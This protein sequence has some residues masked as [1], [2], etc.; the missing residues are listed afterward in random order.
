VEFY[1]NQFTQERDA[2]SFSLLRHIPEL[3]TYEEN[4]D[5]CKL[6]ELDEVRKAIFNLNRDRASGPDGLT[7]RFYQS[8][9]DIVGN[10]IL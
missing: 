7:G 6:P 5:L 8:C 4:S 3:I 2:S 9:W 1:H 10:D